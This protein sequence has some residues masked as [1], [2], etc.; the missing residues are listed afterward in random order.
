M[1]MRLVIKIVD[2]LCIH[3]CSVFLKI[4]IYPLFIYHLSYTAASKTSFAS[5]ADL[6]PPRHLSCLKRGLQ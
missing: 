5:T 2:F 4:D 3:H 6:K 1:P